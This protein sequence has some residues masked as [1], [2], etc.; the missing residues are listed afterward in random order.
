MK[1]QVLSS[2]VIC[3][4]PN[5]FH[6]YFAWPSVARLH[7]GRLAMVA[8]GFAGMQPSQNAE[9]KAVK[10]KKSAKKLV[11]TA[12]FKKGSK[13]YKNKKLTFKFGL[14]S[15]TAK[16]NSKGKAT[17]KITKLTKKGKFT[18]VVT[19]KGSAYYNKTT[20]KVKITTR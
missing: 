19:Y 6:N 18:A 2:K 8:S 3:S 14:S 17:F 13:I 9:A 11:L 20:K 7:D 12:K 1:I 10:V 4:N 5:S 16:T 15:Y